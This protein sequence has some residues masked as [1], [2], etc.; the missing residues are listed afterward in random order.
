[1]RDLSF[2]T[3]STLPQSY[4]IRPSPGPNCSKLRML[5]IRRH[6]YLAHPRNPKGAVARK[7]ANEDEVRDALRAAFPD[8]QVCGEFIITSLMG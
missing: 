4:G 2:H 3:Q 1:M 5:L 8:A 6:D 7:I